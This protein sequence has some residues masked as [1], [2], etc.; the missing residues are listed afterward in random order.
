MSS[1]PRTHYGIHTTPKNE[2]DRE[3]PEEV[4]DEMQRKKAEKQDSLAPIDPFW[5]R[6]SLSLGLP[7]IKEDK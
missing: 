1:I 2:P 4:W 3:I 5:A 7:R 6:A